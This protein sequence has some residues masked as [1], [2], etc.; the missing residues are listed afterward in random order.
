MEK[1]RLP[2]FG[3][4]ARPPVPSHSRADIIRPHNKDSSL[5]QTR[6]A[7]QT[8]APA[9]RGLGDRVNCTNGRNNEDVSGGVRAGGRNNRPD[10]AVNVLDRRGSDSAST[11]IG[12]SDCPQLNNGL[13]QSANTIGVPNREPSQQSC[14]IVPLRTNHDKCDGGDSDEVFLGD[15]HVSHQHKEMFSSFGKGSKT[16]DK[17][18]LPLWQLRGRGRKLP[19][20]PTQGNVPP[21]PPPRGKHGSD[22]H[23]KYDSVTRKAE[24]SGDL[25]GSQGVPSS[26]KHRNT[27]S[28]SINISDHDIYAT[29]PKP[30]SSD[31]TV[32]ITRVAIHSD[33]GHYKELEFTGE[34]HPPGVELS[35]ENNKGYVDVQIPNVEITSRGGGYSALPKP[36]LRT[37]WR[38]PDG[39]GYS[40]YGDS[41]QSSLNQS[42][43]LV[44]KPGNNSVSRVAGPSVNTHLGGYQPLP[45]KGTCAMPSPPPSTTDNGYGYGYGSNRSVP[46]S[47]MDYQDNLDDSFEHIYEEPLSPGQRTSSASSEG[48]APS[49]HLG[50][51]PFASPTCGV[52]MAELRASKRQK[53]PSPEPVRYSPLPGAASGSHYGSNESMGSQYSVHSGSKMNTIREEGDVMMAGDHVYHLY[54]ASM[55]RQA[56]YGRSISLGSPSPG[57]QASPR[58]SGYSEEV[59]PRSASTGHYEE[60]VPASHFTSTTGVYGG[61][62]T[63][64]GESPQDSLHPEDNDLYSTVAPHV[65]ESTNIV[66]ESHRRRDSSGQ[67]YCELS[68]ARHS[69]SRKQSAVPRSKR[70]PSGSGSHGSTSPASSDSHSPG[71]PRPSP[72]SVFGPQLAMNNVYGASVNSVIEQQSK[73]SGSSAT[74]TCSVDEEERANSGDLDTATSGQKNA[75]RERKLQPRPHHAA[76]NS[77]GSTPHSKPKV[78]LKKS[79]LR[80]K[81]SPLDMSLEKSRSDRQRSWVRDDCVRWGDKGD[82]KETVPPPEAQCSD[83]IYNTSSLVRT[84]PS[85]AKQRSIQRVET[86]SGNNTDHDMKGE[87]SEG[88][89]DTPWDLKPTSMLNSPL[90]DYQG[91]ISPKS[92]P[93]TPSN[94][95]D[96]QHLMEKLNQISH[97]H[98]QKS[99]QGGKVTKGKSGLKKIPCEKSPPLEANIQLSNEKSSCPQ[100]PHSHGKYPL[101]RNVSQ[102]SDRSSS[103]SSS[104]NSSRASIASASS[105][106]DASQDRVQ[107]THLKK[108]TKRASKLRTP[109][110]NAK[111]EDSTF[112]RRE[113]SHRDG[114]SGTKAGDGHKRKESK[115]RGGLT[116]QSSG[117]SSTRRIPLPRQSSNDSQSSKGSRSQDVTPPKMSLDGLAARIHQGQDSVLGHCD[118]SRKDATQT[119]VSPP[120]SKLCTPT[121]LTAK[122]AHTRSL[123]KL[124]LQTHGDET[125]VSMPEKEA[126]VKKAPLSKLKKPQVAT[127]STGTQFERMP[128]QERIIFA[129]KKVSDKQGAASACGVVSGRRPVSTPADRTL[130]EPPTKHQQHPDKQHKSLPHK[131]P[132]HDNKSREG[133]PRMSKLRPLSANNKAQS[134]NVER[135]SVNNTGRSNN[136]IDKDIDSANRSNLPKT[137]NDD[138]A[139]ESERLQTVTNK[140]REVNLHEEDY[141]SNLSAVVD[142]AVTSRAI[143]ISESGNGQDVAVTMTAATGSP[144]GGEACVTVVNKDTRMEPATPPLPSLTCHKVISPTDRPTS[145]TT[146]PTAIPAVLV[147]PYASLNRTQPFVPKFTTWT[148]LASPTEQSAP[149]N[150]SHARGLTPEGGKRT[151]PNKSSAEHGHNAS[152][153]T[154]TCD[155]AGQ[156]NMIEGIVTD[157]DIVSQSHF[158]KPAN[159][160]QMCPSHERDHCARNDTAP[161]NNSQELRCDQID[162][163]IL[164]I[165][166]KKDRDSGYVAENEHELST[167]SEVDTVGA[168]CPSCNLCDQGVHL[169]RESRLNK[170]S[171][172]HTTDSLA[173]DL[174]ENHRSESANH[175]KLKNNAAENTSQSS[176]KSHMK[177]SVSG[178]GS[179]CESFQDVCESPESRENTQEISWTSNVVSYHNSSQEVAGKYS[180]H[181]TPSPPPGEPLATTSTCGPLLSNTNID[182]ENKLVSNDPSIIS[183]NTPHGNSRGMDNICASPDEECLDIR[184][185]ESGTNVQSDVVTSQ[186]YSIEERVSCICQPSELCQGK[187]KPNRSSDDKSEMKPPVATD[188]CRVSD[189]REVNSLSTIEEDS[190]VSCLAGTDGGDTLTPAAPTDTTTGESDNATTTTTTA[191]TDSC[192]TCHHNNHATRPCMPP[193]SDSTGYRPKHNNT[194]HKTSTNTDSTATNNNVQTS[195]SRNIRKAQNVEIRALRYGG[196]KPR[197]AIVYPC[198]SL[199]R[200]IK[201][202]AFDFDDGQSLSDTECNAKDP[203]ISPRLRAKL[204]HEYQRRRRELCGSQETLPFGD[205]SFSRDSDSTEHMIPTHDMWEIFRDH[206]GHH[207]IGIGNIRL[208]ESGYDSWKS[209]DSG[210]TVYAQHDSQ[211]E[212]T[213]ESSSRRDPDSEVPSNEGSLSRKEITNLKKEHA[214]SESTI[215]STDSISSSGKSSVRN[216]PLKSSLEDTLLATDQDVSCTEGDEG[217]REQQTLSKVTEVAPSA[218][219]DTTQ[220]SYSLP[221]PDTPL[222]APLPVATDGKPTTP[223]P[224]EN[225]PHVGQILLSCTGTGA[226]V[227]S[228]ID[229]GSRTPVNQNNPKLFAKTDSDE[230]I[231]EEDILLDCEASTYAVIHDGSI[232]VAIGGGVSGSHQDNLSPC[233]LAT[234]STASKALPTR[235][236]I[237]SSSAQVDPVGIKDIATNRGD[238]V[239]S[240]LDI[241]QRAEPAETGWC[242]PSRG[243]LL[244]GNKKNTLQFE[245][246]CDTSPISAHADTSESHLSDEPSVTHQECSKSSPGQP[247]LDPSPPPPKITSPHPG[248]TTV[249]TNTSSPA[250]RHSATGQ[251]VCPGE[252]TPPRSHTNTSD[253]SQPAISSSTI[254][255]SQTSTSLLSSFPACTSSSS[256][257][258]GGDG[259][260]NQGAIPV[261]PNC[262]INSAQGASGVVSKA[263]AKRHGMPAEE[264]EVPDT[265]QAPCLVAI[266][267]DVSRQDSQGS[268]DGY[269]TVCDEFLE[270]IDCNR[271]SNSESSNCQ[272]TDS[273]GEAETVPATR[274][275]PPQSLGPIL[276]V[277]HLNDM[278]LYLRPETSPQRSS[279]S[280]DL[281][282]K[283]I[284]GT[285]LTGES[286]LKRTQASSNLNVDKNPP[287]SGDESAMVRETA[288]SETSLHVFPVGGD[289]QSVLSSRCEISGADQSDNVT[290]S[291]FTG[292]EL[293]ESDTNTLGSDVS[294]RDSLITDT[295]PHS[296]LPSVTSKAGDISPDDQQSH[297]ALG[298]HCVKCPIQEESGEASKAHVLSESDKKRANVRDLISRLEKKYNF[299][300]EN[301]GPNNETSSSNDGKLSPESK[302]PSV[303]HSKRTSSAGT[304]S[305]LPQ[306]GKARSSQEA[307]RS[308]NKP[309]PPKSITTKSPPV[310]PVKGKPGTRKSDVPPPSSPSR[311]KQQSNTHVV[312]ASRNPLLTSSCKIEEGKSSQRRA[313]FSPS[314]QRHVQTD[315]GGKKSPV[316]ARSKLG[317]PLKPRQDVSASHTNLSSKEHEPH[318]Q[319]EKEG[320]KAGV[321]SMVK[322]L[323]SKTDQKAASSRLPK[324]DVQRSDPTKSVK[325]IKCRNS[326][327]ERRGVGESTRKTSN[328]DT[329]VTTTFPGEQLRGIKTPAVA[330]HWES[331]IPG[332]GAAQ[333]RNQQTREIPRR[334]TFGLRKAGAMKS[335][336]KDKVSI[337]T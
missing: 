145:I 87:I 76:G 60:A 253:I 323:N 67:T 117:E 251:P 79:K 259:R 120:A 291:D 296:P 243:P 23:S 24:H 93:S 198:H 104:L 177:D 229:D 220:V 16:R 196:M 20:P 124:K 74:L 241:F 293:T 197:N 272:S 99:A 101:L 319:V 255:P 136:A 246:S 203:E 265:V 33:E 209:Q 172:S 49:P 332:P 11:H 224:D 304:E 170:H 29:L 68:A 276:P 66:Q 98:K 258:S 71:Q 230:T 34:K 51:R 84:K 171:P 202:S 219:D 184:Q 189:S 152:Q 2:R 193:Q 26:H 234:D 333:P 237:S 89:Y 4:K 19:D 7:Q 44:N 82:N 336:A 62:Y 167:I 21:P 42:Y 318:P 36:G 188:K 132:A 12:S 72:S 245:A 47:A 70:H 303:V 135:A 69:A 311:G 285:F 95:D 302:I 283:E 317:R 18:K 297:S 185:R 289:D 244:L 103:L 295:T 97:T 154:K 215:C 284:P 113:P 201:I 131:D 334:T 156:V 27:T 180:N 160:H 127:R 225:G 64:R 299:D 337:A 8:T 40:V 155:S 183:V 142:N 254:M 236:D 314:S 331:K 192:Q 211:D 125:S 312:E 290:G 65:Y 226:L 242:H 38:G 109:I 238:G 46:G 281:P 144:D 228:T 325:D 100:K 294:A 52:R 5:A 92:S 43:K 212:S 54:S 187:S 3:R 260:G 310:S 330:G 217:G 309:P 81:G 106:S 25:P 194:Q 168:D 157:A 327:S 280:P 129:S 165:D 306:F 28:D 88:V 307:S 17:G 233:E 301:D 275:S 50:R 274:A 150:L 138:L 164:A 206:L 107:R 261:I 308:N 173:A 153:T 163:E 216:M 200:K 141:D 121:S 85:H 32:H 143:E 176:E 300:H 37:E 94:V 277:L 161:N 148:K 232:P 266:S 115:L 75:I 30:D 252:D 22:R 14:L 133:T 114:K 162:D 256:S 240:G 130:P 86:F 80:P 174:Q 90:H 169:P 270:A 286:T 149:S 10:G 316:V 35:P 222:G 119:Q 123:T 271:S 13:A 96:D 205:P 91:P 227:N 313:L 191:G 207:G 250:G 287:D 63:A 195:P 279:S 322:Q 147:K 166:Y 146:K 328:P 321:F 204:D 278:P 288:V 137:D 257:S 218:G 57:C 326:E 151:L 235:P 262:S 112:E 31:C 126:S 108:K 190:S 128:F 182:S 208:S 159:H 264:C 116:R 210:S 324:S 199:P 59:S 181:Q 45:P 268:Q 239:D 56:K 329:S 55:S 231:K 73:S 247:C 282:T 267:L 41:H 214:N 122:F 178:A 139:N 223:C 134:A 6:H 186:D 273:L 298:T 249:C 105:E 77:Q 305:R 110:K 111:A 83:S 221:C 53:S 78:L 320:S 248:S 175:D 15:K 102:T 213:S 263:E 118:N 48:L 292:G 179:G 335:S 140:E 58:Q 269:E 39:G 315:S 9:D 1:S 61:K 158:D